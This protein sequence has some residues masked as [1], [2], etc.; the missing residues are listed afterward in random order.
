[1]SNQTQKVEPAAV[2]PKEV[3]QSS[4]LDARFEQELADPNLS[5][6]QRKV[7]EARRAIHQEYAVVFRQLA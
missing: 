4:P 1:M 2:V 7:L 5:E 6:R 3:V